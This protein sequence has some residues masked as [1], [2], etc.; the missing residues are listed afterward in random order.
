MELFNDYFQ[1][2]KCYFIFKVQLI[3]VDIF[4]NF[5]V[6]VYG[7]NFKWYVGGDNK[8]GELE[9]VGKQFF[10]MDKDFCVLEFMYFVSCMLCKELK[11]C[12]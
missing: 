12:G 4:Y 9:L 6:N 2:F 8:N 3:C 1:N 7:F 11:E 10:D 5:G